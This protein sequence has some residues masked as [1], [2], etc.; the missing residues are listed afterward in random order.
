MWLMA[1][2]ALFSIG[3]GLVLTRRNAV[4]LLV[5]VEMMINAA[6]LNFVG[7][8]VRNGAHD[9]ATVAVLYVMV[10]A[11]ASAAVALAVVLHAYRIRRTSEPD[12]LQQ[13]KG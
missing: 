7:H 5:G 2:A 12:Q 10:L 6:G 3:L 1:G 13:L 8:A 11:A 4:A 9:E